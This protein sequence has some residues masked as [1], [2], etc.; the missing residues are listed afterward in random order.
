MGR[1]PEWR[2]Y[3]WVEA[4]VVTVAST[5][6]SITSYLLKVWDF[7]GLAQAIPC[8]IAGCESWWI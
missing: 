1:K 8:L 2:R 4:G 5:V 7:Y 3:F 6:L